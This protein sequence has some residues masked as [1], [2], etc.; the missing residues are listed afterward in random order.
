MALSETEKQ[1]VYLELEQAHF[2]TSNAIAVFNRATV[3]YFILL[4]FAVF[5][6]INNYLTK[7]ML[8]VL[9]MM[10]LGVLFIGA[11]PY[12]RN[13]VYERRTIDALIKKV[14]SKK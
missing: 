4:L 5:G 12:F 2:N 1:L 6:L 8:N 9:V 14:K 11:I 3:M 13:I 7:V 10:G